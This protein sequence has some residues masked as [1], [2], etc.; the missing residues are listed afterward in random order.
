[1]TSAALTQVS[2]PPDSDGSGRLQEVAIHALFHELQQKKYVHWCPTPETQELTMRKR[3]ALAKLDGEDIVAA[4]SVHDLWGWSLHDD[5]VAH[6][7]SIL[8]RC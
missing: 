6:R 3:A 2:A 8:K 5:S 4:R 1:M 7:H